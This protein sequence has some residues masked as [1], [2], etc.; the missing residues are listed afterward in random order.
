LS[1]IP[2]K[3]Y[4]NSFIFLIDSGND[5]SPLET[6]V[7]ALAGVFCGQRKGENCLIAHPKRSPLLDLNKGP[8]LTYIDTGPLK[9]MA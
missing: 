9:G 6:D 3:R 8:T 7:F 1:K 2:R 5:G 4:A